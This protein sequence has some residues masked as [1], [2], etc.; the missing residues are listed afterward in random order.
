MKKEINIILR[1]FTL[2]AV[3]V[4]AALVFAA[5]AYF[6]DRIIMT[7]VVCVILAAAAI[8][9]V[10]ISGKVS[11]SLT[12]R[13][14]R[15]VNGADINNLGKAEIYEE[16]K[17]FFEHI[18]EEHEEK[19][20]A[21]KIRREFTAN[22]SHELKTPITTISGYAQMI[23]NGMAKSEDIT[24]FCVKIDKESQRLLTLINDIINL[25]NLDEGEAENLSEDID[26]SEITVE[27]ICS[28]RQT[29]K[30]RGI[31]IF[32]SK[33]PTRIK[34]NA[35]L[36]SELVY[37]LIDNAIKYNKDN[38]R[39]RVFVGERADGVEFS[40]KDT[41]IGIPE[42]DTERIFERFYR[43]DKSHS[44]KVGG[45]GLGLSIVKHICAVHDAQIR[46]KSVVGKGTTVYVTFPRS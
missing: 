18:A 33:I 30:E 39:I 40:V 7:A 37:N 23:N 5:C 21:E 35:T 36:I 13:L 29:A 42:E 2:S 44:K 34:G 3:I 43:V 1:I 45:T 41:G 6:R 15:P 46:V 22:V 12:E 17:P 8:T 20:K 16:L 24:E 14:M 11:Q 32:Y 28:L 19:T 26:L 31:Q 10:L 27:A 38:G 25:S 9:V 4:T